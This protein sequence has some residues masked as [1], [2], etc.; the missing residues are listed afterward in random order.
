PSSRFPRSPVVIARTRPRRAIGR[1]P[2]HPAPAMATTVG[3]SRP[4]RRQLLALLGA[5]GLAAAGG[6]H[7]LGGSD[8]SALVFP[9]LAPT[10]TAGPAPAPVAAGAPSA[11]VAGRLLVVVELRG[12]NDGLAT[13]VPDSGR[14][15]DLRPTVLNDDTPLVDFVPGTRLHP[16]LAGLRD[17]GLAVVQGIGT[18]VPDGSHF[19]METRWWQGDSAGDLS[20]RTGFLGRVCDELAEP[21]TITG[22]TVGQAASPFLTADKATTIGIPDPWAGWF[23][24]EDDAWFD[25]LRRGL[26]SMAG[27]PAGADPLALAR[28]GLGDALAFGELLESL[29]AEAEA[30]YEA[31]DD[32]VTGREAKG[33]PD[34]DLAF[35]LQIAAGLLES[36]TGVRV[37]HVELG[38]FDTHDGQM[39]QH[40]DLMGN[41]GSSLAAFQDDLAARGLAE[42]TLT[43]TTSEFGRRPDDNSSGTDHGTAAP[44][45]LCGPVNAGLFAD[46]PALDRLDDDG[47]LVATTMLDDYYATIAQ[48]WLGI[49]AGLV[50]P[51]G[52]TVINE[53]FA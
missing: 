31:G 21:G 26:R 50:L 18:A 52:G 36:D 24:G 32:G 14:L 9:G 22:V 20:I 12:G 38:G 42:R 29:Q 44:A 5:G 40:D 34:T 51:N 28:A 15:R 47:N 2:R 4:T 33:Y 7:L 16:E 25:N 30:V 35:Q 45:L 43:L 13:V 19:E 53:L 41:L 10:L 49:D 27:E 8:G 39:Y 37:V 23:L 17:R 6:R 11:D 3:R 48:G 46:A 1:R